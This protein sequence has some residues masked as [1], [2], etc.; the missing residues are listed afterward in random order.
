MVGEKA[1]SNGWSVAVVRGAGPGRR[2]A[3]APGRVVL[4]R[5]PRAGLDLSIHEP[6]NAPRRLAE[7][8][9]ELE[10][11]GANLA[12]RDLGSPGGTLVNRVRLT[13]A[14]SRPLAAG[15]VIQLG[16]VQLQVIQGSDSES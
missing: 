15:D 5:G 14:A 8:Q 10:L 16:P 9:A 1:E 13:G 2:Y 6:P 11:S 7:R 12:I 3:I 4:G